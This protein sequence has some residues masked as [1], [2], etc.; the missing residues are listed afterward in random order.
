LGS[1]GSRALIKQTW[2]IASENLLRAEKLFRVR[3]GL[4]EW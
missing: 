1:T 4:V 2:P 3:F